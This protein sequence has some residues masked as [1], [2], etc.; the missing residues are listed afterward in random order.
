MLRCVNMV[1]ADNLCALDKTF[2]NQKLVGAVD[3]AA[4]NTHRV[5]DW[6]TAGRDVVAVADA[7]S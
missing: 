6:H 5:D 4:A 2:G 1:R 7:A 3:T